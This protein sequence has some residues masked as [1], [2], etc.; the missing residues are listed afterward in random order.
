MTCRA[1]PGRS[2]GRGA[3]TAQPNRKSTQELFD[4][5]VTLN[6]CGLPKTGRFIHLMQERGVDPDAVHRILIEHGRV[7][8]LN[9]SSTISP[10]LANLTVTVQVDGTRITDTYRRLVELY[11]IPEG[12]LAP[13][14]AVSTNVLSAAL[15]ADEVTTKQTEPSR[16]S[17]G[18]RNL[19]WDSAPNYGPFNSG[20]I[21]MIERSG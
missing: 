9:R 11:G 15:G 13:A 8:P 21:P 12:T 20:G 1:N 16:R 10:D 4:L 5:V 18:S 17:R 19:H 2:K 7:V 6:V 3:M 14:L